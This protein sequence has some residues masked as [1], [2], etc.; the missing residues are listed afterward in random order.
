MVNSS[1][2]QSE[3]C[4]FFV[5]LYSIY[6]APCWFTVKTAGLQPSG[7]VSFL[8]L[9]QSQISLPVRVPVLSFLSLTA[10]NFI[11]KS[12][13]HFHAEARKWIKFC[14]MTRYD[15]IHLSIHEIPCE[16]KYYVL[17]ERKTG[18]LADCLLQH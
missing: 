10:E 3:D 8:L 17:L 6:F 18:K 5:L 12:R 13:Y 1:K 15:K 4:L 7:T 14:R 16:E 11:F 2:F 9:S